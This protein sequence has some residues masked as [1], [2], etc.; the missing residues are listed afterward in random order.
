MKDYSLAKNHIID[1]QDGIDD[2]SCQRSDIKA[3]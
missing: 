2:L 1:M 3:F